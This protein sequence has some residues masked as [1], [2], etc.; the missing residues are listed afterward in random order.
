MSTNLHLVASHRKQRIARFPDG[1]GRRIAVRIRRSK[2]RVPSI[3]S[4]SRP[5][6]RKFELA[7]VPLVRD[8]ASL[9]VEGYEPEM[10]LRSA[11]VFR[12]IWMAPRPHSGFSDASNSSKRL[13]L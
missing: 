7:E 8:G 5:T 9:L 1:I 12:F 3:K 2:Q 11:G 10:A 6:C 13:S 4:L